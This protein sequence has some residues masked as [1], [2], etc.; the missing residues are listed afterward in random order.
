M[1]TDFQIGSIVNLG[2]YNFQLLKA[3]EF[4]LNYM[5]ERPQKFPE[6]SIEAALNEVKALARNH[7]SFNDFLIWFVKSKELLMQ[8]SILKTRVLWVTMSSVVTWA[9]TWS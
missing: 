6:V 9:D 3:D 4:T 2:A 5:K 7:K 8:T 1:D